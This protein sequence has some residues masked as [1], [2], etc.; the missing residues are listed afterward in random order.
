MVER[1]RFPGSRVTNAT[2]LGAAANFASLTVGGRGG[3]S[4]TFRQLGGATRLSAAASTGTS[5]AWARGI[6][7]SGQ[8]KCYNDPGGRQHGRFADTLRPTP[9]TAPPS[10]SATGTRSRFDGNSIGPQFPDRR[11]M[12]ITPLADSG[13]RRGSLGRHDR[14]PARGQTANYQA[15]CLAVHYGLLAVLATNQG[16]HGTGGG[17]L[18]K[19]FD[20]PPSRPPLRRQGLAVTPTF[21]TR[22]LIAPCKAGLT[23]DLHGEPETPGIRRQCRTNTEYGPADRTGHR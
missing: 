23:A 18:A 12:F 19:N 14:G 20:R 16:E 17:G 7:S 5:L 22:F 21:S 8:A 9:G 13:N 4:S 1:R 3:Q 15:G 10:T 6:Q 11:C 2:R